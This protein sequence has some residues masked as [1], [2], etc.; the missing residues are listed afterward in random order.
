[1]ENKHS[2]VLGILS[3]DEELPPPPWKNY[4]YPILVERVPGALVEKVI[5]GDETVISNYIQAGEKLIKRGASA[6]ASTCGFTIRFQKQ[7]S[8]ALGVPVAASSLLLAP[9]LAATYNDTIGII[10]IDS[11]ALKPSDLGYA[12]IKE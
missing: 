3:L 4:D 9:F 11:R 1:M 6:L 2:H 8:S 12:G 7:L 10:T 5:A